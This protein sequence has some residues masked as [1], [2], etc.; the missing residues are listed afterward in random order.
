MY[1]TI[2]TFIYKNDYNRGHI[3]LYRLLINIHDN[4]R[5]ILSVQLLKLTNYFFRYGKIY[6]SRINI[7]QN[8]RKY[9]TSAYC[10]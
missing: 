8:S 1:I 2:I 4:A 6:I 10:L 3:I 7:H 9:Y 5:I